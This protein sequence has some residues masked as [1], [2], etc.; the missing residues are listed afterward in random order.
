MFIEDAKLPNYGQKR[1]R[2][3]FSNYQCIERN[4]SMCFK[5]FKEIYKCVIHV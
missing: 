1:V 4:R 2:Y 5:N 3:I